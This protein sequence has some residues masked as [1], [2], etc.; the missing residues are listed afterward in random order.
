MPTVSLLIIQNILLHTGQ[1]C[2]NNSTTSKTDFN[3]NEPCSIQKHQRYTLLPSPLPEQQNIIF[4]IQYSNIHQYSLLIFNSLTTETETIRS[5]PSESITNVDLS[6]NSVN[7][8][9]H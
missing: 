6:I 3:T 1:N 2:N 5:E 9:N 7:N 4:T 8:F